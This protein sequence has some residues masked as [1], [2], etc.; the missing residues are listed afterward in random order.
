MTIK[1]F[2]AN[3]AANAL[4]IFLVCGL[5]TAAAGAEELS[6]KELRKLDKQAERA[7][8][9]DQ[10]DQAATLY[11]QLLDATSAGDDRR[12][13]A[14]WV[15]ALSRL[16]AEPGDEVGREHLQELTDSFPRHPRQRE[17]AVLRAVLARLDGARVEI[18]GVQAKLEAQLEASEAERQ[19][20]E[21]EQEKIAGESEEADDRIRSLEN[22]LRRVRAELA[23]TEEELDKKEEALQR[24]LKLRSERG[25]G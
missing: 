19:K 8:K 21:Q 24:L 17:L 18:D 20:I 12:R 11:Q 7:L 16:T 13:D 25:S 14:L 1:P 10:D 23:A 5:G 4:A 6:P 22:Q 3:A 2:F 9:A 15:V